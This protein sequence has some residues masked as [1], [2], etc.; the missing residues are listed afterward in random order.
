MYKTEKNENNNLI[1]DYCETYDTQNKNMFKFYY[2]LNLDGF[3]YL[4]SHGCETAGKKEEGLK[5]TRFNC[6]INKDCSHLGLMIDK[7]KAMDIAGDNGIIVEFYMPCNYE[8]Y[9]IVQWIFDQTYHKQENIQ[10]IQNIPKIC[11]ESSIDK[12]DINYSYKQES[13]PMEV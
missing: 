11:R 12:P 1:W 8:P 2:P 3:D 5:E 7:Q 13:I 9:G 4:H 10:N 6:Y